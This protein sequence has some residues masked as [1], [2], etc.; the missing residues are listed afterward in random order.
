LVIYRIGG[1]KRPRPV[2]ATQ[3]AC[4]P[5]LEAFEAR[6]LLCALHD[7]G[8]EGV[9][10]TFI[11]G[12]NAPVELHVDPDEPTGM[13]G[14]T[15]A[16]LQSQQT[17]LFTPITGWATAANGLPILNSLP[18]APTSIYLD[19]DGDTGS[20]TSA[21]S[22]DA[23]LTTYNATEQTHIVEAWRQITAYFAMFDTNVT[24]QFV[25]SA[26]KAWEMIGNGAGGATGGYAYVGTFPNSSPEAFNA[27][28]NATSRESGMAHELGHVFGLQHQSSYDNLGV[29][30]NEYISAVDSL[31]GAIM[32]V[33]YSGT[34]H[35]WFIGHSATGVTSLQD[36]M[37]VIS[38]KIKAKEA[39]GGDGYRP[40]DFANTIATA[41]P[42]NVNGGLQY[43]SGIIER[44]T[45]V[46][47]EAISNRQELLSFLQ[48]K[49][50]FLHHRT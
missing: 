45:D 49:T 25:S 46:D 38:G 30:I 1:K 17:D 4:R 5:L 35:K 7:E 8:G 23:D 34:V 44:R 29:K 32:G 47:A 3:N 48:K 12:L 50:G 16:D 20:S 9:H 36:D 39:A 19:F 18:G 6:I 33:D 37:A 15:T 43:A 14:P 21:Y 27:S 22:E 2:V 13:V 26:P 10:I 28:G 11:D 31:H 24:T 42:L 41:A 40:D